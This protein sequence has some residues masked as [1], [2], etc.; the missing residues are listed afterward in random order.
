MTEENEEQ[1]R[2]IKIC[3]FC[4]R[5]LIIE[6]MRDQYQLT[7]KYIGPAHQNCIFI[8]TQQQSN[9]ISIAFGNFSN[10]GCHLF[11]KRLADK[12]ND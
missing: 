10:Y 6:K 3:R 12:K 9:F 5:E 2:K 7:V 8:V 11:F 4:A 1:Y